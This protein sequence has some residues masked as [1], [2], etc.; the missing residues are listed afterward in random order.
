MKKQCSLIIG[1]TGFIGSSLLKIINTEKD[2]FTIS[3]SYRD[4][5]NHFQM[6]ISN[7]EEFKD[8][9]FQLSEKFDHLDIYYLAGESSVDSSISKPVL[10]FSKSVKP[11]LVLLESMKGKSSTIVYSSTGAI[12]DSREESY[13]VESSS[14]YPPS[15][16]AASKHACEGLAMSYYET[17]NLDVRIARIFSVFGPKMN[18]FFIYDLIEKISKGEKSIQ[19]YGNGKQVRDY[20]HVDDVSKGLVTIIKNGKAGD[21]YNLSSGKPT[22]LSNLSDKI[23]KILEIKDVKILWDAAETIGVRDQW[24]G[25]NSKIQEIG[26][27]TKDNFDDQLQSAVREIYSK[28]N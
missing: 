8:T 1:S 14:L 16:Y 20:L 17:Y 4:A 19:L 18:R 21:I 13:F 24:Y 10:S 28:F 23:I 22:S 2:I 6:D 3:R 15:P 9:L 11:F 26:F 25:D 5:S 12:Y 27:R 7:L